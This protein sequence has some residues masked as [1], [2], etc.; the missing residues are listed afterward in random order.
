MEVGV[1]LVDPH[2]STRRLTDV[3][4]RAEQLGYRGA[5]TNESIAREAFSTLAAWAA[6]TTR[7]RLGTGVSPVYLRSPMAAAIAAASCGT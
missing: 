3:V 6:A 2:L 4:V 1:S 5:W 7:I